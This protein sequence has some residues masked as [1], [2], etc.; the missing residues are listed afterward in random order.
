[1]ATKHLS[2]SMIREIIRL[3]KGQSQGEGED[4][5]TPQE[6]RDFKHVLQYKYEV[7]EPALS[8]A[9]YYPESILAADLL[10]EIGFFE[11]ESEQE[12]SAPAVSAAPVVEEP[13]VV[14]NESSDD[15]DDEHDDP[16]ADEDSE[17][18]SSYELNEDSDDEPNDLL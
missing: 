15:S 13:P 18:E 16:L 9:A 17:D 7:F 2:A 10:R 11:G 14:V 3:G 1:M 4:P 5:I 6:E 12:E 8:C